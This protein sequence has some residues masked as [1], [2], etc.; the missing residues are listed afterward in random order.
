MADLEIGIRIR[1]AVEGLRNGLN[2]AQASISSFATSATAQINSVATSTH[3]SLSGIG[4]NVSSSLSSAVSSISSASS[5]MLSSVTSGVS[6]SVSAVSGGITSMR[7]TLNESLGNMRGAFAALGIGALANDILKTNREMESLRVQLVSVTGSAEK[8]AEAFDSL[9]KLATETPFEINGLTKSYVM[10][11]NFGLEPSAKVMDALTNQVAKLG[12]GADTL[13]G[14]TLALGQAWGK[15][16]LQAQDINQMVER[17]VPVYDLLTK[18]TGKQSAELLKMSE[19]GEITREVME[20]LIAKMGEMA[21]G[22]NLRAM[23]TLNGKISVLADSWHKFEDAL[24]QDKSEGF[25]KNIV[26]N[27]SGWLDVLSDK[28]NDNG[29]KLQKL[30]ELNE[31][32]VSRKRTISFFET[33][34]IKATALAVATGT[35][36]GEEENALK[37]DLIERQKLI[38]SIN[39]ERN[40]K[41]QIADIEAAKLAESK[42]LAATQM[43]MAAH[44]QKV[45]DWSEKYANNA[46]KMASELAKARKELGS[47]FTPAIEKAI[48]EKFSKGSSGSKGGMS[49]L[50]NELNRKAGI[51]GFDAGAVKAAFEQAAKTSGIPINIIM[52]QAYTESKFDPHAKSPTG[53]VGIS[54][55][56][57]GTAGDFN[58]K[59]RT[60]PIESIRAQGEYMAMLMK[61]FHGNITQALHAYNGGQGTMQKVNA[62]NA[63]MSAEMRNYPG[64][65]YGYAGKSGDEEK[66]GLDTAK[67]QYNSELAALKQQHEAKLALAENTQEAKFAIAENNIE[68]AVKSA[69]FGSKTAISALDRLKEQGKIGTNEYYAALTAEQEKAIKANITAISQKMALASDKFAQNKASAKPQD[70]PKIKADYKIQHDKYIQ[71]TQQLNAAILSLYETNNAALKKENDKARL[72]E[73]NEIEKAALARLT[74]EKETAQ[75]Q[76][77]VG[78]I[79]NEAF[80]ARL[81][82]FEDRRTAIVK[83]AIEARRKL[84][85]GKGAPVGGE[86]PAKTEDTR[87]AANSKGIGNKKTQAKDAAFQSAFAPLNNAL[88][89]S[90]NGILTG[91]QTIKNAAKNAAQSIVLSYASAFVKTRIMSAAQWAWEAAGFAGVEAKKKAISK[92]GEVWQGVQWLGKKAKLA[93][94]WI[95]EVLGFGS[96]EATKTAVHATAEIA[97][98]GATVAGAGIRKA[99]EEDSNKSSLMGILSGASSKIFAKAGEAAASVYAS[100]AQIPYVGWIL[101]PVAAGAAFIAVSAFGMMGSAEKGEWQVGE[102]GSPFILHKKESVLPAG[103]ADNF[104]KV[105]GIVDGKLNGTEKQAHIDTVNE[106]FSSG[107]IAKQLT[108]SAAALNVSSSSKNAANG[109]A[110]DHVNAAKSKAQ[111][112]LGG[113]GGDVHNHYNGI[114]VPPEDFF[115]QNSKTIVKAASK[116]HR[117]FNVGKK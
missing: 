25:I 109:M 18:V 115:M 63:T 51:H 101:A 80:L 55:F 82:A 113:G 98:T 103:V 35:Y 116:E 99:A 73:I 87:H 36:K 92:A 60:N 112:S 31:R 91:Q 117:N 100:V 3:A 1:L 58:L 8:G 88:D 7:D 17:G 9:L 5:S 14:V 38:E 28:L 96:K 19:N 108:L 52:G 105:V 83:A 71:D 110:R 97:Q 93:G 33:D 16:K 114:M 44:S 24:L 45:A 11:K 43:E 6:S 30:D 64:K 69:E 78:E 57:K 81:Q 2:E 62:G 102:D 86:D 12:G 20:R 76:L 15:G 77:D 39:A 94:Q 37:A 90:V 47:D 22:S 56:L 84:E 34:P 104:R 10:L 40:T 79:D 89:Q 48:T 50:E 41:K 107:K 95:W 85:G 49:F 68:L 106:L 54:Q 75:L 23:E 61:M 27:W 32:I 74:I 21:E 13:A 67:G 65:V 29:G 111:T 66:E 72:D 70:L 53:A 26:S 59:D 42:K 4:S 46:Q